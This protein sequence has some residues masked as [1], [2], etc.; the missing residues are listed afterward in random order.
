METTVTTLLRDHHS[1]K[2]IAQ[3]MGAMAHPTRMKILCML[4]NREQTVND[5]LAEIGTSQS[6]I[7]QHV[8]ALR[9]A[10]LIRSRRNRYYVYCSLAHS[11][12]ERIIL[13]VRDLF[14]PQQR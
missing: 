11:E 1:A 14:C 2:T 10:G 9:R 13:M 4:A 5:L 7:S 3:V 8:D 6:N 12:M